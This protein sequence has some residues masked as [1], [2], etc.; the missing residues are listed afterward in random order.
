M[1]KKKIETEKNE[2]F[3]TADGNFPEENPDQGIK[4]KSF[5]F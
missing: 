3:F 1:E 4:Y 5:I 2:N